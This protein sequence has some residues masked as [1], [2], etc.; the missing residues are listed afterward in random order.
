MEKDKRGT[1]MG[2]QQENIIESGYRFDVEKFKH[3]ISTCDV[4]D[5]GKISLLHYTV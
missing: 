3:L 4:T 5:I 1:K 2:E